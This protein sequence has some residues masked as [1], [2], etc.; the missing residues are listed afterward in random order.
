MASLGVEG[1]A[2]E[3]TPKNGLSRGNRQIST[4]RAITTNVTKYHREQDS[5]DTRI[6]TKQCRD[7]DKGNA[8]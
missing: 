3:R 5:L 1:N 4:S 8:L 2:A 6:R 7:S